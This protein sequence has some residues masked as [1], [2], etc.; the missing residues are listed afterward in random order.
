[1]IPQ[2]CQI[3]MSRADQSLDI[4][5]HLGNKSACI[6]A[7]ITQLTATTH[8]IPDFHQDFIEIDG[9][10]LDWREKLCTFAGKTIPDQDFSRPNTT[11]TPQ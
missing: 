4:S 1:M 7:L 3:L 10:K 2:T 9:S 5:P 6:R 11:V 8:T